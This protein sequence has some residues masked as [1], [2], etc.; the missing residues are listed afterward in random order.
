M[1]LPKSLAENARRKQGRVSADN[2]TAW[3]ETKEGAK[4]IR[5]A[6][7]QTLPFLANDAEFA[8]LGRREG[9]HAENGFSVAAPNCNGI[10]RQE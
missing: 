5:Q 7:A 3:M 8:K 1:Q 10:S 2:H 9:L 6:F 4:G